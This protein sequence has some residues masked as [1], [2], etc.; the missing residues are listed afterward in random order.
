MVFNKDDDET[1]DD[2]RERFRK[3]TPSY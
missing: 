3:A 2:I 1:S